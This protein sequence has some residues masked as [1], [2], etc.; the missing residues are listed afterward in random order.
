MPWPVAARESVRASG[1][2]LPDEVPAKVAGFYERIFGWKVQH[3]LEPGMGKFSL[4]T[5][6]EGRMMGLWKSK[7]K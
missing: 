2:P 4:F 6:P 7:M 3:R 5:D 1:L